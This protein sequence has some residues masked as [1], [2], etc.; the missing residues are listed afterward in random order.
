MRKQIL[1][2]FAPSRSLKKEYSGLI[3]QTDEIIHLLDKTIE[4]FVTVKKQNQSVC[5]LC[6]NNQL[7][8]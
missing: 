5:L 2:D 4:G 8:Y 7:L 6:S 3:S 1:C